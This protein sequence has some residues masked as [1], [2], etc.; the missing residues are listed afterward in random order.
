VWA[1]SLGTIYIVEYEGHR[2]RAVSP[3]GVISTA[4]GTGIAGGGGDN[5]PV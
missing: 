2:V 4:V 1:N 5:G 3:S